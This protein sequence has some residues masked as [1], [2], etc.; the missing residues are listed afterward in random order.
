[1]ISYILTITSVPLIMV[2]LYS[3]S[4]GKA[5]E[6]EQGN[7]IL[8]LPKFYWFLGAFMI[9]VGVAFLVAAN[10]YVDVMDDKEIV[11]YISLGAALLGSL[12]FAKGYISKIVVTET[13][14]IE[15]GLF[16]QIT[17]INLNE[18]ESISFGSVSQEL[19]IK[20]KGKKIK[21]HVHLVGF[22]ELIGKLVKKTGKTPE[23]MGLQIGK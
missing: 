10:F 1:M 2:M 21:A 23:E 16:G 7:L 20:S 12:L 8:R 11:L 14:I 15:T 4:K 19:T 17:Q 9:L 3:A 6:D 5:K 18:T 13:D 22:E